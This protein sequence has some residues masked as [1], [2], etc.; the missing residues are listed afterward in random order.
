MCGACDGLCKSKNRVRKHITGDSQHGVSVHCCVLEIDGSL[1]VS[2]YDELKLIDNSSCMFQPETFRLETLRICV[3]C[4]RYL[5][6]YDEKN[7]KV[8]ARTLRYVDREAHLRPGL[9]LD[10]LVL[11]RHVNIAVSIVSSAVV[12]FREISAS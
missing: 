9:P 5:S 1:T 12:L 6:V 10:G 2:S 11:S 7:L 4:F 3:W 8:H